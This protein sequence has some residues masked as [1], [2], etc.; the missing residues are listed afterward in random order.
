MSLVMCRSYTVKVYN[1]FNS[2]T[3]FKDILICNY[4]IKI[5]YWDPSSHVAHI[6][7]SILHF[8]YTPTNCPVNTISILQ[9]GIVL[10]RTWITKKRELLQILSWTARSSQI[11]L[12]TCFPNLVLVTQT[13]MRYKFRGFTPGCATNKNIKGDKSTLKRRKM[14]GHVTGSVFS[15]VLTNCQNSGWGL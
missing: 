9:H 10:R 15:T 7:A 4:T 8:K 12:T 14:A 6:Q 1:T 13:G 5:T 11:R 3:N 2:S